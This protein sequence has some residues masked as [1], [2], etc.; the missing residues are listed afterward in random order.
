M[1][2]C[3]PSVRAPHTLPTHNPVQ[4]ELA[5]A[6]NG[7][8]GSVRQGGC[9]QST[10]LL[11]LAM[12]FVRDPPRPRARGPLLLVVRLHRRRGREG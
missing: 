6:A 7:G 11:G 3:R 10:L 1:E 4:N 12:T 5:G 2:P 9:A 8:R